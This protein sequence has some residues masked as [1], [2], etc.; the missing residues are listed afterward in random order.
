[1]NIA[2]GHFLHLDDGSFSGIRVDFGK[3]YFSVH[4][5]SSRTL[6]ET[7]Q[8]YLEDLQYRFGCDIRYVRH[9]YCTCRTCR[10][11]DSFGATY[12]KDLTS[13]RE[14]VVERSLS[15]AE[16]EYIPT[17]VATKWNGQPA[18]WLWTDGGTGKAGI[19]GSG[20]GVFGEGVEISHPITCTRQFGMSSNHAEITAAL[21][22][23]KAADARRDLVIATDST[24]VEALLCKGISPS[25]DPAVREVSQQA[26]SAA[27]KFLSHGRKIF[28]HRV[29]G[30]VLE[31]NEKADALATAAALESLGDLKD[32]LVGP[33]P[34]VDVS[35]DFTQVLDL[36]GLGF[37]LSERESDTEP[38]PEPEIGPHTVIR[39]RKSGAFCDLP[40]MAP[41]LRP[42]SSVEF[43]GEVGEVALRQEGNMVYLSD[44]TSHTNFRSDIPVRLGARGDRWIEI[45]PA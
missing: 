8:Y 30:H 27:L 2:V 37:D 20:A 24:V 23:L 40:P 29:P 44:G 10:A 12:E 19:L 42:A 34:K 31:N 11:L 17:G 33:K 4:K 16:Q 3:Q 45:L 6:A 13:L 36:S 18:R 7:L 25:L 35:E 21:L 22:A 5:G 9:N 41:I 15:Y 32:L 38:E 14:M 43:Q 26:V 39:R 28:V 1:M